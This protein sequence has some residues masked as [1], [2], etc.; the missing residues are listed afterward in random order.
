MGTGMPARKAARHTCASLG[1]AAIQYAIETGS[2]KYVDLLLKNG[3]W[4]VAENLKEIGVKISP[5][6]TK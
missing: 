4:T 6:P 3:R 5:L 1:N 2:N